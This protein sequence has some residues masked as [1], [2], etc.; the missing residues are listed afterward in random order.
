MNL[1]LVQQLYLLLRD[2][3]RVWC[4]K[5]TTDLTASEVLAD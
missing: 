5:Q 1:E 2:I 4:S 3:W